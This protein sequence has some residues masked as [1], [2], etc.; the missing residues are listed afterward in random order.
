MGFLSM[1]GA[2]Y[3]ALAV[4]TEVTEKF[5]GAGYISKPGL[6]KGRG[7][8]SVLVRGVTVD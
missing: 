8:L 7:D 3:A 5:C 1:K 2:E 4:I 6:G